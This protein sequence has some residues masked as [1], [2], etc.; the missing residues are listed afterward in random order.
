MSKSFDPVLEDV[1]STF[2][3]DGSTFGTVMYGKVADD[4]FFL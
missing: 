3:D 4:P 1:L 2:E